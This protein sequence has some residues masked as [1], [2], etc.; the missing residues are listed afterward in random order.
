M[1]T[2][3]QLTAKSLSGQCISMEEYASKVV[4]VVNTASHCGFTPQYAGLEALYKKYADQ[5][6][7]V[8]GFPCNQFGKQEPGGAEEI[9]QT[10]Y[11]NYGVSFPMFEKVDVNGSAA[12]PV[13]RYLKRELPGLLGG[14]VKW[15]F[16]KFLIGRDG[17]PLKRFAP[18]TTPEKMEVAI[19]AAL[20]I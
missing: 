8:L 11:I 9:G 2:F 12:H 4:L 1:T 5:G 13:F 3:Y 18:F 7:V 6:F 15:N 17:K 20:K 16:T 19:V 14:R 10:C